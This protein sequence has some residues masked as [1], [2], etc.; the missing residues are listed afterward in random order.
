MSSN[1]EKRQAR[2][3][4]TA[5]AVERQVRIYHFYYPGQQPTETVGKWRK[6]KAFNCGQARCKMCCNPRRVWGWVT[7]PEKRA[8]VAF[9]QAL[10]DLD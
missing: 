9:Q 8:E 6:R 10:A 3:R 5:H 1:K 2:R 7:F 4:D